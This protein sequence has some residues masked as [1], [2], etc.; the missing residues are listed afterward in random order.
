MS[1]DS[2]NIS[3]KLPN[4]VTLECCVCH[5]GLFLTTD[6][7]FLVGAPSFFFDLWNGREYCIDHRPAPQPRQTI[8][9]P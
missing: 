1:D 2:F 6:T 3:S 9:S 4:V 5:R 7:Y 8:T